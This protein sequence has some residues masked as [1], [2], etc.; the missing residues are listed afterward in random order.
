MRPRVMWRNCWDSNLVPAAV[1]EAPQRKAVALAVTL[2]AHSSMHRAKGSALSDQPL[3]HLWLRIRDICAAWATDQ[4][5][6]RVSD[7]CGFRRRNVRIRGTRPCTTKI[8]RN[9]QKG[10][11]M[12]LPLKAFIHLRPREDEGQKRRLSL[13]RLGSICFFLILCLA[14]T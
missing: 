10:D 12:P 3:I 1:N 2:R 11:S 14:F 4:L 13:R 9:T 6:M 7:S 5:I 8:W